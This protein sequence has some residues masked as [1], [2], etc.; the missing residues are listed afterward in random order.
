[1]DC[2]SVQLFLKYAKRFHL[3]VVWLSSAAVVLDWSTSI[4]IT[5]STSCYVCTSSWLFF[6]N[7]FINVPGVLTYSAAIMLDES[8]VATLLPPLGAVELGVDGSFAFNPPWPDDCMLCLHLLMMC[9]IFCLHPLMIHC[10][11]CLS[12]WLVF[13]HLPHLL[14]FLKHQ[15]QHYFH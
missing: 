2:S 7:L 6:L 1:M 15:Y 10:L 13:D 3:F 14:W 5:F 9:W 11:F 4:N 12:I 8:P